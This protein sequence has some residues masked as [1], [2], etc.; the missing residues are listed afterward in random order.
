MSLTI[1]FSQ[2][3]RQDAR[4]NRSIKALRKESRRAGDERR[5]RISRNYRR[6]T[7]QALTSEIA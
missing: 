4:L 7:R 2:I 3:A 6:I 5:E 1:D